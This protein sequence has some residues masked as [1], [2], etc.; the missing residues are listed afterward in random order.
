MVGAKV[1]QGSREIRARHRFWRVLLAYEHNNAPMCKFE[2]EKANALLLL[3]I[4][5]KLIYCRGQ[6]NDNINLLSPF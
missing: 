3:G 4:P 5:P 6:Y 1:P 2:I